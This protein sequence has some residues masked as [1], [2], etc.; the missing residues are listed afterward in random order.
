VTDIATD[1]ISGAKFISTLDLNVQANNTMS[2]GMMGM[3]YLQNLN[4]LTY[5]EKY[6]TAVSDTCAATC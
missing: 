4:R 1:F 5:E 6:V 2:N 3:I